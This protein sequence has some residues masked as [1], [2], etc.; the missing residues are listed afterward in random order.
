MAGQ[1][2]VGISGLE[3]TAEEREVLMHPRIAGVILFGRNFQDKVQLKALNN[4]IH[5]L[6]P[7]EH[8]L[9]T[10]VDQEGGRVQRFR[11]GFT[12]LPAARDL[13]TDD[14][15]HE[16][17]EIMVRELRAVDVDQSFAPVVDLDRGCPVIESRS[18]SA[19]PEVVIERARSFM[20]GM[21]TGKMGPILK[22]FPGHGSALSDTHLTV[23]EDPRTLVEMLEADLIPFAHFIVSGVFGMMVSHVIYPRVDRFPASISTRWIKEILR[24]HM[25]FRGKLFSDD[26]GMEAIRA[27]GTPLELVEQVFAVGINYALLCNDWSQVLEVLDGLE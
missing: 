6:R 15:A 10:Y 18:F 26:L 9:M 5:A 14:A 12:A 21:G 11:E 27:W 4:E 1:L 22:H 8:R 2:I 20:I 17:G 25:G 24:E 19:D 7:F 13:K 23:T 16:A 3:L